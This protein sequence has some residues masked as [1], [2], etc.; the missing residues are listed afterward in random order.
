MNLSHD[1]WKSILTIVVAAHGIGYALFLAPLMGIAT[2]GQST[3]SWLLSPALG[4][5]VAQ[6]IGSL[7]FLAVT[8]AFLATGFGTFTETA[9][10]RTLAVASAAVSLL[11]LA[12]FVDGRPNQSALS[13]AAF[14]VI[15]WRPC[16]GCNGRRRT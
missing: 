2:W 4:N 3:R 10:R 13:A 5:A 9:W 12:L 15:I 7:L 11:A 6:G 14:D 8:I 16:S 1:A